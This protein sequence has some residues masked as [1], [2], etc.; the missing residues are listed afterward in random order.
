MYWDPGT[1]CMIAITDP[2]GKSNERNKWWCFWKTLSLQR[3]VLFYFIFCSIL[4]RAPTCS[5]KACLG[6]QISAIK[7][8][9][10][11]T[12]TILG[13]LTPGKG[14]CR[15]NFTSGKLQ[16]VA[17]SVLWEGRGDLT[18]VIRNVKCQK[19]EDKN[20]TCDAGSRSAV[21]GGL[22]TSPS[23]LPLSGWSG[24]NDCSA[25]WGQPPPPPRMVTGS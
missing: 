20:M 9:S 15:S 21:C 18:W 10:V 4:Y 23:T 6:W 13:V 5:P 16:K 1:F 3:N 25:Y 17:R 22:T 19:A 24:W 11:G 14:C 8:G 7:A 2:A 12:V